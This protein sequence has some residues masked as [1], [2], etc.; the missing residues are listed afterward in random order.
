MGSQFQWILLVVVIV[1]HCHCRWHTWIDW[2]FSFRLLS[3]SSFSSINC[4]SPNTLSSC[5]TQPHPPHT[6]R[7]N[8]NVLLWPQNDD[9]DLVIHLTPGIIKGRHFLTFLSLFHFDWLIGQQRRCLVALITHTF[10]LPHDDHGR[11]E[12]HRTTPNRYCP[13]LTY[14]L[15]GQ[16]PSTVAPLWRTDD[17]TGI[18]AHVRRRQFTTTLYVRNQNMHWWYLE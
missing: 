17:G 4:K 7:H 10:S 14:L 15:D 1:V 13:A 12:P 8:W 16:T 9:N 5:A 2:F 11:T 18:F 6:D 3:F